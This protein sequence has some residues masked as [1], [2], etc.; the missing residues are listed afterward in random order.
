MSG[1]RAWK[2][3]GLGCIRGI[4]S[5]L[6]DSI[7]NTYEK[8]GMRCWRDSEWAGIKLE[9]SFQDS[10]P[11]HLTQ[12]IHFTRTSTHTTLSGS[13][14][15][16]CSL[17]PHTWVISILSSSSPRSHRTASSDSLNHFTNHQCGPREYPSPGFRSSPSCH[18]AGRHDM[19]DGETEREFGS[20]DCSVKS[21]DYECQRLI[22]ILIPFFLGHMNTPASLQSLAFC[23]VDGLL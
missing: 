7:Q 5:P 1:E 20:L 6:W 15:Q 23:C 12:L 2:P 16:H 4:C 13:T 17:S 19:P 8:G 21:P 10:L 18:E 3:R 11:T 14:R 9:W 22:Q